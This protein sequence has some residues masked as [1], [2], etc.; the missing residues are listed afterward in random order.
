MLYLGKIIM[1]PINKSTLRR[2]LIQ[3][4]T[5]LSPTQWREKSDRLCEQIQ[6]FTIYQE[7]KT[8]LAYFS[9]RQEPD[10]SPLFTSNQHRW[11][12]PRCVGKSLLWHLWQP[13]EKLAQGKFGILEPLPDA[14]IIGA[15]DVD[16]I[17]VPAVAGDRQGYRLG[18]GGGF[19]DRLLSNAQWEN[20]PTV[21]IIFEFAYL[22]QLPT[23]I[24]DIQLKYICT[25]KSLYSC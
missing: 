25:E 11:G 17:L 6:S 2:S 8:V 18:Y 7:A 23:D 19:Y 12:F 15:Q 3:Q 21:L 24:W 20:I 9:F 13:E 16:L 14:P 22:P 1:P 10:L 4:R 5:A